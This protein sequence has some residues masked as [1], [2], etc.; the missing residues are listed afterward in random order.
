MTFH[1]DRFDLGRF[2]RETLAEDLGEA[3]DITSAAVVEA[4]A[5]FSGV[6]D[7]REPIVA[8]GLPVAEAFFRALDPHVGIERLVEDGGKAPAGADLLRRARCSPPSGRRSTSSS[9][10]RASPR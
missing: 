8:A 6:M 10:F 2:V 1:L 3:G 5:R 9:T 4:D 7:C